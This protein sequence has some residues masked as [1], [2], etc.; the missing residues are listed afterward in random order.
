[1]S[2]QNNG[3]L[4]SGKITFVGANEKKSDKLSVQKVWVQTLEQY[5]QTL[6]LQLN[7]KTFNG[8]VNDTG[9][10][11]INLRGRQWQDKVFNT[12][13]CWKWEIDQL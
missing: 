11:H 6:E 3:I 13:E 8:R 2:N 9:V 1:M 5:P 4:I 10:F 7:N 12:L